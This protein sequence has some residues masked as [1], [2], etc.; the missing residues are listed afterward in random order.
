MLPF[1]NVGKNL[2]RIFRCF[3]KSPQDLKLSFGN[4]TINRKKIKEG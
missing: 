4:V 3:L 2:K 1:G